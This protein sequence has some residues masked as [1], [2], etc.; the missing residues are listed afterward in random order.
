MGEMGEMFR[1]L[2]AERQAQRAKWGVNCPTCLKERPRGNATLLLPGQTCKVDKFRDPRR[3][4]DGAMTAMG[5]LMRLGPNNTLLEI[6]E[7]DIINADA[8]S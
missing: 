3:I 1:D 8:S 6:K 7:E 2:K 5:V 4:R